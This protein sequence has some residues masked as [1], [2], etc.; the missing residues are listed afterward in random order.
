MKVLTVGGFT[1]YD[2]GRRRRRTT[3]QSDLQA[4]DPPNPPVE[5]AATH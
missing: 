3:R 1:E 2:Q 5:L 4:E